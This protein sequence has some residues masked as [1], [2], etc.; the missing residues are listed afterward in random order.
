MNKL[1]T[2]DDIKAVRQI[3]SNVDNVESIDPYIIEA[4]IIDLRK[5]LGVKFFNVFR[6]EIETTPTP[7]DRATDILN[8]CKYFVDETEIE[9]AGIKPLIAYY[10][11]AR[12]L[13]NLGKRV[14][15]TGAVK[16]INNF[17]DPVEKDELAD[18]IIEAKSIAKVFEEDLLYFLHNNK[19]TYPEFFALS[20]KG[21][22]RP[23]IRITS[24]GG[25]D[26]E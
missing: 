12:A 11:Y 16:K 3:S 17:S 1:I 4:Q 14:T 20:G 10:A 8:G 22:I 2:L 5:L 18:M 23:G 24:V 25:C 9:F 7:P 19:E 21:S 26:Y 13:P 6:K 15:R